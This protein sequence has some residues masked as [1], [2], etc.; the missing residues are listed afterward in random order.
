MTLP[1]LTGVI[2]LQVQA[3]SAMPDWRIFPADFRRFNMLRMQYLKFPLIIFLIIVYLSG[4]NVKKHDTS[5]IESELLGSDMAFSDMSKLMGAEKA[6]EAFAHEE[7]VFLKPKHL[8]I[9][10]KEK[11]LEFLHRNSGQPGELTW[12][13]MRAIASVSGDLGY[14]YGTYLWKSDTILRRGTYLTIWKKDKT[15]AWKYVLDTGNSGLAE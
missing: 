13:P 4:C 12:K 9:E 11:I 1:V 7:A 8:P 3:V 2:S 15:G 6:F 14:T 5:R 10:G